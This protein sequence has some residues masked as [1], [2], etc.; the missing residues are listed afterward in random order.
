MTRKVL[1]VLFALY[2]MAKISDAYSIYTGDP[3]DQA[4]CCTGLLFLA[5]LFL[6][7][8]RLEKRYIKH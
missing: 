3:D 5:I 6:V 4:L 2:V 1:L 7:V 8:Q